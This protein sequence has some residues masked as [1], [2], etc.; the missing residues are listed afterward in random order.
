MY[1]FRGG[2]IQPILTSV[3][4]TQVSSIIPKKSLSW[5]PSIVC[6]PSS[7]LLTHLRER[8]VCICCLLIFPLPPS[9]HPHLDS[10]NSDWRQSNFCCQIQWALF[11]PY[12][13]WQIWHQWLL[14]PSRNTFWSW[15]SFCFLTAPQFPWQVLLLLPIP[16]MASKVLSCLVLPS[17][18]TSSV[19][20]S[21]YSVAQK[22]LWFLM[23]VFLCWSYGLRVFQLPWQWFL[24]VY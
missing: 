20:C 17:H 9:S 15:F 6:S 22:P 19:V 8:I 18:P 12:C 16:E 10:S 21:I 14:P 23:W 3:K 7:L 4:N 5:P 11:G 2:T 24:T 13:I 1:E